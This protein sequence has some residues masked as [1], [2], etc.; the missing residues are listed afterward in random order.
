MGAAERE[1]ANERGG[2]ACQLNCLICCHHIND[3]SILGSVCGLFAGL[4][5]PLHWEPWPY[6]LG[7]SGVRLSLAPRPL[8]SLGSGGTQGFGL[9]EFSL[10]AGIWCSDRWAKHRLPCT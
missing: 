5:S 7:A 9:R 6:G 2:S 4:W 10:I 8:P 1:R 3:E